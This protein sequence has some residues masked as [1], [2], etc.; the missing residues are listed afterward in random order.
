MCRS[1]IFSCL[2]LILLAIPTWATESTPP[3]T[4]P[5]ISES[6]P[7]PLSLMDLSETAVAKLKPLQLELRRI[8]IIERDQLAT[9]HVAFNQETDALRSLA[10][11][12]QIRD[13]KIS[14]ERALVQAQIDHAL[15][16][17]RQADAERLENVLHLMYQP[18]TDADTSAPGQP[19]PSAKQRTQR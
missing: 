17:G 18:E 10:I 13:V 14:T 5:T 12:K 7:A 1:H 19:Q 4:D 15:Q 11:Q 2:F 6:K 16:A 9:L 3:A 8:L